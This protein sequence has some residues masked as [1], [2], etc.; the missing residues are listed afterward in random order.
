MKVTEND[1]TEIANTACMALRQSF[2]DNQEKIL[3]SM[4]RAIDE[5]DADEDLAPFAFG[6]AIKVDLDDQAQK[7]KF[8]FKGPTITSESTAHITLEEDDQ[9]EL[10][11][12]AGD[13]GLKG[14]GTGDSGAPLE[15]EV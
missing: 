4:N 12:E 2:Q 15:P 11:F 6:F 13:G 9:P 1:L 10:V 3:E 8:S 7:H 5:T 14:A